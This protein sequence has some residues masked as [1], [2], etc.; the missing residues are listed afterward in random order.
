MNIVVINGSSRK[1]GATAKILKEISNLLNTYNN[2]D[3]RFINLSDVEMEFCKGCYSCY[4]TGECFIQDDVEQI[5]E[6]ISKADGI[7]IGTPTYE[8]N[9]SGQLKVLADRGHFVFEQ[10]LHQQYALTV[11]TFENYGGGTASKILN[12]LMT[13]SGATLSASIKKKIFFNE[14]PLDKVTKKNLEKAVRRF[15]L[16]IEKRRIHPFQWVKQKI[17]FEMGIKPFVYKKAAR[18]TGI[19]DGVFKHW[20]DKQINFKHI[21]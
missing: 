19:F 4:K 5:I 12:N 18:Y 15:Y 2:I 3:V 17:I 16:D 11:T 20:K 8:S 21:D 14:D 10:L 7:I 13:Y 6:L 1:N 9:I